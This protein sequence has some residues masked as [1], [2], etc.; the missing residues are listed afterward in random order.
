MHGLTAADVLDLWDLAQARPDDLGRALLARA[1][2]GLSEA[3]RAALPVGRRDAALLDLRVRC[4]GPLAHA[5]A[6]CPA[7]QEALELDLP[8]PALR[9]DPPPLPAGG[10]TVERDGV[11]L[12]LRLPT[13]ADVAAAAADPD[14]ERALLARCALEITAGDQQCSIDHVPHD[15]VMEASYRAAELDPQADVDLALACPAC[16]H[17]WS[18]A[19][20][21]LP[22]YRA[23]LRASALRLAREVDALARAYHWRE[24]DILAMSPARRQLYLDLAGA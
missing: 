4:F 7:C 19:F 2:P 16:D 1:L 8:L 9:V 12:R 23:E 18:A 5:R 22:F 15:M 14:P 20:D 13:E 10:L 11:R 24:A 17:R 21:V 3:E 6:T